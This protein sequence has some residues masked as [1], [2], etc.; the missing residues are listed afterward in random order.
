[1]PELERLDLLGVR[2]PANSARTLLKLEMMDSGERLEVLL[3]DGE[4]ADNVPSAISEA[5]H[6]LVLRARAGKG[7]R[8]VFEKGA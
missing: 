7:W 1:M 6:K 5:G 8:M 2:C 3:D 4:P